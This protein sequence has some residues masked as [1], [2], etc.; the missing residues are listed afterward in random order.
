MSG[1]RLGWGEALAALQ[2][3]KNEIRIARPKGARGR[4]LLSSLGRV[5]SAP[6]EELRADTF[7]CSDAV[8]VSSKTVS[9]E[10]C[11]PVSGHG[12]QDFCSCS[13]RTAA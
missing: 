9:R 7:A 4:L 5:G 8:T 12:T 10:V 1:H 6:G 11:L 2:G 3:I 13:E